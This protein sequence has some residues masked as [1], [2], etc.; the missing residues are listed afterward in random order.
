V[1]AEAGSLVAI[2]GEFTG[3]LNRNYEYVDVKHDGA[4]VMRLGMKSTRYMTR[5]LDGS[6]GGCYKDSETIYIPASFYN[7]RLDATNSMVFDFDV[8]CRVHPYCQ[9]DFAVLTIKVLKPKCVDSS[10]LRSSLPSLPDVN[11]PGTCSPETSTKQVSYEGNDLSLTFSNLPEAEPGTTVAIKG[12]FTGDLN[13]SYEYADVKQGGL[14]L[15]RLGQRP[16]ASMTRTQDG[17]GGG[18]YKD[19]E[20]IYISASEFNTLRAN[21][22][23]FLFDIRSTVHPYCV[24]DFAELSITVQKPLNCKKQISESLQAPAEIQQAR[25]SGT[26][27]D[28]HFKTWKLEHFEFHGQC[29]M[30]LAK[31]TQFADGI[32]LDVQIRTNIVRFWSYIRNAAIRIGDDILEIQ[33]SPDNEDDDTHYWFNFQYQADTAAIGGFPLTIRS[34]GVHKRFFE[35]DLSSKF[36]G[37]KIVLSTFKEFVSVDFKGNTAES[38][39]NTVGMLG[40]YKSG[41][42][43][44]RDGVTE[45]HDFNELGNEWQLLPSDNMLFH[46]KA[47]PQ[48]PKRCILPEDPQGQR[49]RRLDESTISVEQ[50]E[51]ACATLKDPLTIKDCVYDIL[52]TQDMDMVGA[53]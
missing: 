28:P 36:P 51:A 46:D 20:T 24:D 10:V 2:T 8:T 12:E 6:S 5:T 40:D 32:G 34:N 35:I 38:F 11:P 45:I 16:T 41:K 13:R 17:L 50:A 47:E 30:I 1:E 43:F 15:F 3:D 27:G 33:G 53:F 25:S 23:V 18:C 48:F 19:S 37:Q 22:I 14:S 7:S 31:D 49:R 4:R 42:T 52:A 21:P 9:D 39:G 44:A 26:N 29:D